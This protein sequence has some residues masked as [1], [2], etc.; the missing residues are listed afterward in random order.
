MIGS[1]INTI[2]VLYQHLYHAVDIW[3]TIWIYF[4]FFKSCIYA[5]LKL[6]HSLFSGVLL[7]FPLLIIL[8]EALNQMSC[9]PTRSPDNLS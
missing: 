1:A 2:P 9:S 5:M 6:K 3:I 7:Y 8:Q 4:F